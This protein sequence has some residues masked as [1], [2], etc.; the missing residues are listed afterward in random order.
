LQSS[1]TNNNARAVSTDHI[2][3]LNVT[4]G[5]LAADS[6]TNSKIAVNA[7]TGNELADNSVDTNSIIDLNVTVGKL[8]NN[9][10][11]VGKLNTTNVGTLGQVLTK[12][13]NQF[14]WADD[15]S[16]V[17]D[18]AVGGAVSGTI[19]NITIN[20]NAITSSMIAPGVIIAQDIAANA[21]NGTHLQMGS[22]AAG[23]ILYY[24]GTDYTRL[25]VGSNDQVLTVSSG[26]PAWVTG[27]SGGVSAA[28]ATATAV[29]MA[30]ALG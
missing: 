13:G 30:I 22:D 1:A 26:S 5:K 9:A 7:V 18:P 25:G 11:T 14:T 2:K 15:T 12:N 6:V 20:D 24:D 3:D 16:G 23:D 27:A 21:I 29:T 8:A 4:E 28:A 10:I 17:S 19:S